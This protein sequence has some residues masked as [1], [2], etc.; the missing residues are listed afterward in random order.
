MRLP[1]GKMWTRVG[2]M[3]PGIFDQ[4]C[5]LYDP[6]YESPI[7]D[8]FAWH[9]VKYLH[10]GVRFDKQVW[11]NT[12]CGRFR[13]DFVAERDG[14]R[15]AFECDGESFHDELRD[16]CRDAVIVWGGE[17]DAIYRLRGVDITYHIEDVLA[18]CASRDPVIF[19][20]RGITNLRRLMSSTAREHLGLPKGRAWFWYPPD[21]NDPPSLLRSVRLERRQRLEAPY[22][23]GRYLRDFFIFAWER[24]GGDL[25][26]MIELWRA[27]DR[28]LVA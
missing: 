23:P 5:P 11:V 18:L 22:G 14:Y 9:A 21:E 12:I 20:E 2:S 10:P 19:S 17:V 3:L 27:R 28:G 24:G 7:E 26:Q 15:V 4:T 13:L 6:P 16:E 1:E 8:I 25:D